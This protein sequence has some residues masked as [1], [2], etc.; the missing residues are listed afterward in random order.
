MSTA[1]SNSDR[2]LAAALELLNLMRIQLETSAIDRDELLDQVTRASEYC[3]RFSS[4]VQEQKSSARFEAL[5]HVSRILGTSLELQTVLDQV[6]DAIIQLTNA[7]RGFLVLRND[8][9]DIAIKAAR[10]IDQQTLASSE[11]QFS[12]TIVNS[13][14]DTGE[15]ILATNAVEDP[16]FADRISIISQSLRSIMAVP[17]RIRGSVIGIAYVDNRVVAGLFNQDDLA[18]FEMLGGQAAVAIDNAMLFSATD[19]ALAHR[20]DQLRELRRIDLRLNEKLD[21]DDVIHYTLEAACRLSHVEEAYLLNPTKDDRAGFPVLRYVCLGDRQP[22]L[23]SRLQLIS[24]SLQSIVEHGQSRIVNEHVSLSFLLVPIKRDD[25]IGGIVVLLRDDGEQFTEEQQDLIERVVARAAVSMENARLYAQVQAADRAKSEFVG[26][27]AHDLKAPMTS[28]RG[29]AD[30][31]LMQQSQISPPHVL[32]LERIR[33]TVRHM[34]ILVSDLTD[35]SRIESGQISMSEMQV[36]VLTVTQAVKDTSLPE[37]ESRKHRYHEDIEPGLPDM[38]VDY[39]RLLQVLTNLI[40]NAIKY[41]PAGGDITLQ[42]NRTSDRICF[43]VSDTGVGLTAA[44]IQ[45]LGTKFWRADDEFTRSQPG[46]GLGLAITANLVAL[47]GSEL[48]ISSEPGQGST[49]SFSVAICSP[50]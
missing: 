4:T 25:K 32:F 49:F 15:A 46:T 45:M 37:I 36:G 38:W 28:I 13:I 8:D 12:R 23:D 40:S 44:Q 29:Y 27:V 24:S 6:M 42:V 39:Y 14:L 7:E 21:L 5:Y 20:I 43:S 17:L 33:S 31:M 35:I 34:E 9:G 48:Q 16:R 10:N 30:L 11:M 3:Q 50:G 19:E 1:S 41:T 26:L 22:T 18:V 2:D 47:M